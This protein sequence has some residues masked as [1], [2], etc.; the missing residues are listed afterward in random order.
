MYKVYFRTWHRG[1]IRHAERLPG[2][3][4]V[5]V[6]ANHASFV[7][8]PLIGLCCRREMFYLARD[9]L[10]RNPLAG[11]LLR[12]WNVLPLKRDGGDLAAMRTVLRM[13]D[14]GKAVLMFPEGTRSKDGRLQ[15]PRAGLG[16]IAAR[17]GVPI[18]PLRIFGTA[19][20]MPRGASLPRPRRITVAFGDPFTPVLPAD[21]EQRRG[22]ELKKIYLDIGRE[23]MGRIAALVEEEAGE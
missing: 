8:P 11:W 2:T 19:A 3:G 1:R 23:V 9:S 10:F 5:I 16:M 4:G 12:S 21:F 6:A 15:E 13:L 14:E 17:A 18:V 22:E 20:V 7:D